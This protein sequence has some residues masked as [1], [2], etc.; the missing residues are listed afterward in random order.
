MR[1]ADEKKAKNKNLFIIFFAGGVTIYLPPTP[2]VPFCHKFW[3]HIVETRPPL[4]F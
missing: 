1:R 2:Y 3:V 4:I